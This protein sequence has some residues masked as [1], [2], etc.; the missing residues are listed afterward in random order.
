MKKIIILISIIVFI[1]AAVFCA[2]KHNEPKETIETPK[3][4]VIK[5][6]TPIKIEQKK[7]PKKPILRDE[8]DMPKSDVNVPEIG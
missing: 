1:L 5:Q 6:E 8:N 3:Q 2:I 4:E 7:S